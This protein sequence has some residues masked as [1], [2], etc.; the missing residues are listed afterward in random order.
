[1]KGEIKPD[2]MPVN[3]YQFLVVGLIPLTATEVSGIEDEL[4][5]VRLPDRTT[6]SGGNR[7]PTEFELTMPMHH[8]TEQAAMEVWFKEGQDPILP[9]YK[10]PCTLVH[11]SISGAVL[12]SYTLV[13]VFPTKRTLPDLDKANEGE[14]ATVVWTMS[15]DDVFPL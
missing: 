10:K 4:E 1:M 14:M 11:K 6:A 7:G 3:K 12:R 9:T 13:G 15:A 5:T 8:L 2:H